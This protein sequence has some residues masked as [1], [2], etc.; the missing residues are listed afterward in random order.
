MSDFK[1]RPRLDG[2]V[3]AGRGEEGGQSAVSWA[4]IIAGALVACAATLILLALGTGLGFSAVSPWSHEGMSASTLALMTVVWLIVVQWIASALGGYVAG[5]LR[6]RW[7]SVHRDEVY[8]RD[9]AHGLLSWALAT[10]V[11]VTLFSSAVTNTIEGGASALGSVSQGAM[12][13][14]ATAAGPISEYDVDTLLRPAQP[15]A[16]AQ[17]ADPQMTSEV[18]RIVRNAV[19]A[20]DVPPADRTYLAQL[21]AQRAG[22]SQEDAQRRVDQSIERGKEAVRRTQQA[23]DEA[24]KA[25]AKLAMFTAL[26]MLIGAFVASAAAAYGGRLRDDPY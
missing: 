25:A 8:F 14:A 24:R 11:T 17:P 12:Q 15:G 19:T 21:I 6:T 20:G 4:A 10:F 5:R 7:L 22:I 18:T 2:D 13:T 16:A 3:A 9:T 26:A 1:A 23:A